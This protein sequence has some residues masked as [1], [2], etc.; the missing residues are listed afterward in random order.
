MI[1]SYF[2]GAKVCTMFNVAVL[3]GISAGFLLSKTGHVQL[4]TAVDPI[5]SIFIALYLLYNGIRLTSSNF[6]SLADYPL[7]EEDQLR[8]LATLT[9]QYDKY[10]DIGNIYTRQ[11]GD[12]KFISVELFLLKGTTM[13]EISELQNAMQKDLEETFTNI[14]FSIVPLLSPNDTK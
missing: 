7:P 10:E 9:R 12:T 13:T 11:S 1:Y 5:L 8:L 14:D 3:I 2:I 6:R 4:A